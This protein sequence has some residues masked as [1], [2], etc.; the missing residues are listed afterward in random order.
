MQKYLNS[1]DITLSL[2]VFLAHDSYENRPDTISATSIIKPLR[3]LV[4]TDRV[5]PSEGLVD[6][7]HL[8]PSRLGTAVHDGIEAAWRAEYQSSMLDLGYTPKII[9]K[10][11]INP[12]ETTSTD[13]IP[14]YLEQRHY[15]ELDGVTISGK[16]DIVINGQLEDFKSTGVYTYVK[17]TKEDDY[18]QQLSIYRWLAPHIIT[19]DFAQINYIFMDWQAARAKS[20]KLYPVNR[21]M[22]IKLPLMSLD[23]T[24][25][26]IRNKLA[27]YTM[28]KDA[29]EEDIPQCTTKELWRNDPIWKYYKN[30]SKIQGRSL[31][32]FTDKQSAY[33]RLSED[34]NVGIVLE[35]PGEVRACKYCSAFSVC[36]QKDQLIADGSLKL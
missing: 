33:N 4:L 18:I 26:F 28:Y 32:N 30:P 10:I 16:F 7:A 31:K 15:R 17:N 19:A 35:V 5:S 13:E 1:T 25:A 12:T 21:I 14:V 23:A 29:P 6:I 3:Q 22:S 36:S 11:R 9:D 8:I 24:E 34:N 2:A 27:Q 20:E